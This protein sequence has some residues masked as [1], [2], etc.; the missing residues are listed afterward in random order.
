MR[1][2]LVDVGKSG[3]GGLVVELTKAVTGLNA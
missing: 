2:A 3:A 1:D